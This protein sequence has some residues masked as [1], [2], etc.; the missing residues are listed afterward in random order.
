MIKRLILRYLKRDIKCEL[1]CAVRA[2][3]E[4]ALQTKMMY[5]LHEILYIFFSQKQRDLIDLLDVRGRGVHRMEN[6]YGFPGS[7]CIAVPDAIIQ[8][9][10]SYDKA[11]NKYT[12]PPLAIFEMKKITIDPVTGIDPT[13]GK[14]LGK[15]YTWYKP[16]KGRGRTQLEA[17]MQYLPNGPHYTGRTQYVICTNGI[18]WEFYDK[19]DL[20]PKPSSS[21]YLGK[22]SHKCVAQGARVNINTK[23]FNALVNEIIKIYR[24]I[25]Y[26]IS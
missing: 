15:A 21:Y 16:V 19:Y 7:T 2:D 13:T 1:N 8:N 5:F 9:A 14:C 22:S 20:S 17:N 24:T 3:D 11:K 18:Y 4:D 12:K 25:L 10:K 6:H 23:E 26:R